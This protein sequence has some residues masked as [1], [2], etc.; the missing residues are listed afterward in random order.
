M[1]PNASGEVNRSTAKWSRRK[2]V[3][4]MLRKAICYVNTDFKHDEI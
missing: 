1:K 2:A 3:A 4:L